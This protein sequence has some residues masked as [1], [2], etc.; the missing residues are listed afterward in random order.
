MLNSLIK[1]VKK[2]RKRIL[3][4]VVFFI[5]GNKGVLNCNVNRYCKFDKNVMFGNSN[6][7]N[8]CMKYGSGKVQ[9]GKNFH[10]ARGLVLLTDIHN[11]QGS[12]L[13]YDD[14]IITK[15]IKIGDN[16]WIGMNVTILGGIEIGNGA[17]I[18]AGS[19]VVC[20]IP[21]LGIA[22]GNPARVFKYRDE[23]HYNEINKS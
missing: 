20:N 16:V 21:D 17:I 23:K 5:S 11:Y 6:H 13:P 18:Q 2:I 3:K 15:N 7:F 10:S 1:K 19:V 22:G 9:F 4:Y 8:G 14:G 12:R